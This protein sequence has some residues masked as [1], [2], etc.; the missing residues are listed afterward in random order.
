MSVYAVITDNADDEVRKA[1]AD[2]WPNHHFFVND[3]LTLV[4]P[5]EPITTT[6]DVSAAAGIGPEGGRLGIVFEIS[7]R[8]GFHKSDLWEWLR[9][10][11]A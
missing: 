2:R 11:E 4:A 6:K 1:L 3:R 10:A 5:E 9:K 8:S 7:A